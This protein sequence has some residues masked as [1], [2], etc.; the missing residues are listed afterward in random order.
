MQVEDT[1]QVK[2]CF[3]SIKVQLELAKSGVI[4]RLRYVSIP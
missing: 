1:T 3:N 4:K 2:K